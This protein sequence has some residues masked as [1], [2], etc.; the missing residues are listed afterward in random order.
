MITTWNICSKIVDRYL[1]RESNA[2]D[3]WAAVWRSTLMTL[4]R[5]P[6]GTEP[7]RGDENPCKFYTNAFSGGAKGRID[8]A[9]PAFRPKAGRFPVS[10]R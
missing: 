3:K 10:R 2:G 6:A 8:R 4:R 9:R 1:V 7:K 5:R